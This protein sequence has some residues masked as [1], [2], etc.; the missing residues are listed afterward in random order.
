MCPPNKWDVKADPPGPGRKKW[1]TR[2]RGP[3]PGQL[4]ASGCC[5]VF[6]TQMPRRVLRSV[7]GLNLFSCQDPRTARPLRLSF[8]VLHVRG[9]PG[10]FRTSV[11]GFPHQ[12][13]TP[14]I[15]VPFEA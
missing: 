14:W 2:A 4:E 12:L 10:S 8:I 3:D 1:T 15:T 5:P 13:R 7:S 9:T 6:L 11:A